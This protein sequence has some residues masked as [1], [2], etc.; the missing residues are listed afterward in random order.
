M[1]PRAY[2]KRS[3]GERRARPGGKGG[4]PGG[5]LGGVRSTRGVPGAS[6][7]VIHSRKISYF[8]N[9]HDLYIIIYHFI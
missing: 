8:I 6:D 5:G 9:F 3:I 1:L 7:G 4:G 2:A